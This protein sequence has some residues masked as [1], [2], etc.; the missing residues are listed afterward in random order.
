MTEFFFAEPVLTRDALTV[1]QLN[2]AVSGL[3]A[4]GFPSVVVR[5]EMGQFSRA[6]SGHWYFTLKDATAQVRC[7]MFRARNAL[8]DFVPKEGDAVELRGNVTVYEARGDYQLNVEA[9]TKAGLGKRYEEFLRLK[10]ALQAE[11][12]FDEAGKRAVPA[13]PRTIGVITSLA[14]AALRDVLTT[15]KRRAPYA[16]V[17]VY[18]VPVQGEGAGEQ[19][20]AMLARASALAHADVLLLV[21]GGG[22]IEDL[23]AFNEAVVA[24][25][26]RACAL[27]VI[28]G[29]GHESDIT[30][31]DLAADL[32]APT[33][34]A[35]AELA[36]ASAQDLLDRVVRAYGRI[37]RQSAHQLAQAAQRLD[38]ARRALAAPRAVFKAQHQ[39]V[40]DLS[41]RLHGALHRRRREASEQLRLGEAALDAAIQHRLAQTR[42]RVDALTLALQHLD[43]H[44][45]LARGYSLTRDAQGRVI[46]D[47]SAIKVGQTL[48]TV[49]AQGALTSVVQQVGPD[50]SA[51]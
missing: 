49:L 35:A 51:N 15:L 39:R 8:V 28:C 20:A 12:L 3:L 41:E 42:A 36:A 14:A 6:A 33:P 11:G 37:A 43:P 48:H 23:W 32:R 38:Y 22:S 34:T 16:S 26:I 4:R 50:E 27:P 18:P 29:V 13:V 2:R 47:A 7:V 31:A 46:R 21:R 44:R 10:S 19:I 40:R 24:R 30:I 25:A 9:L 1:S 5:G 45:V 17:I